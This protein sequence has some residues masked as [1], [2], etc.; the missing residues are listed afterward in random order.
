MVIK[1]CYSDP[2]N[3]RAAA[4]KDLIGAGDL[5]PMVLTWWSSSLGYRRY[6][7]IIGLKSPLFVNSRLPDQENFG[8]GL[9]SVLQQEIPWGR[10]P[11]IL[12]ASGGPHDMLERCSV[13]CFFRTDLRPS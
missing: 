10:D 11:L 5:Y 1:L 4:L 12:V 3:A 8:A 2:G 13:G 9:Q 7:A 6:A